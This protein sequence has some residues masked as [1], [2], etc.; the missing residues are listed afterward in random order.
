ML[1]HEGPLHDARFSR[2]DLTS[3]FAVLPCAQIMT[4][5]TPQG[6]SRTHIVKAIYGI[7]DKATE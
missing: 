2:H 5:S 1:Q 7:V 6:Q 3:P 4:G